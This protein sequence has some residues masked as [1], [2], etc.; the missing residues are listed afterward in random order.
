[1]KI[2]NN[3]ANHYRETNHNIGNKLVQSNNICK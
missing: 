1:M 3:D 2:A